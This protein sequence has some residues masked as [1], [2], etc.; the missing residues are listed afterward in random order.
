MI[1]GTLIGKPGKI[2]ANVIGSKTKRNFT[3]TRCRRK[4][5][6]LGF[7]ESEESG[8]Y[9]LSDHGAISTVRN[10]RWN[11]YVENF[12]QVALLKSEVAEG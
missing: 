7:K 4:L 2:V 1:I 5:Y 8:N 12:L 9:Y 11:D 10:W 3:I 6:S